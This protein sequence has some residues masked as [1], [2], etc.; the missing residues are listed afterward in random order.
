MKENKE[1]L[2]NKINRIGQTVINCLNGRG[3]SKVIIG[4]IIV[5]ANNN[6]VKNMEMFYK[7]LENKLVY[8][9]ELI[10]RDDFNDSV[11]EQRYLELQN[12]LY[13]LRNFCFSCGDKWKYMT[14]VINNNGNFN[15]DF[16]YES[17]EVIE[18]RR[19]NGLLK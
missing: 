1:I 6:E 9:N 19:L 14:L 2:N 7:D 13:D 18:W 17:I 15:V 3:F 5:N 10:Y 11:E 16:K 12:L 4:L 8:F